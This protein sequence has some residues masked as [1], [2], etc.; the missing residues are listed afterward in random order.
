MSDA[1][2]TEQTVRTGGRDI[3]VAETGTGPAVVLLHGGNQWYWS[4]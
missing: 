3:F 2:L 1:T 4:L